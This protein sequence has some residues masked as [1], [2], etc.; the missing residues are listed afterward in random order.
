MLRNELDRRLEPSIAIPA[1]GR[2]VVVSTVL[3]AR[4]IANGLLR[5]RSDGP[6]TMAVI[7]AEETKRDDE[8]IAVLDSR[9]LA[10]GRVYLHRV[11]EIQQR[12]I[13]SR[14]AG[15]ALGDTYQASIQHDLG[16]GALHVPLT[17]TVRHNFRTRDVQVNQ[18]ATRMIDSALDNVG[19]YGVRYD[20]SMNL[21]DPAN[22][23]W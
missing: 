8:L 6:F 10:P 7:T 22:I 5:G 9:R 14:V 23:S 18:L 20:V 11:R 17:S 19:T 15:V 1:G 2:T 12:K 21:S 3:P 13:F 4:G 16:Q